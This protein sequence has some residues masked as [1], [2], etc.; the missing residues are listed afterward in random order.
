MARTY[1]QIKN[2]IT[3]AYIGDATIIAKYGLDPSKTFE[4]QFSMLSLENIIFSVVAACMLTVEVLFDI[5]KSEVT[6]IIDNMKP[7]SP[8]W[9]ADKSKQFQYGFDLLPDS[10]NFDNTGK[11]DSEI[12]D[13]KIVAYSAVIEQKQKLQIKVAKIENNDLAPL[14]LDETDAFSNYIQKIKDAGV[15][16]DLLTYPADELKLDLLIYYNPLVLNSNGERIDGTS[17]TPIPNAIR[18]YLAGIEFDSTVV[19]ADLVD[20]L[21][22]VEGV[23]IPHVNDAAY[24]YGD[25]GWIP[26]N[27]MFRPLSGYTRISDADLFITYTPRSTV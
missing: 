3:S 24:K 21:Q 6:K 16:I 5:H 12:E 27:V 13:S 7:H 14:T 23:S 19:L 20:V 26:F 8:K 10:D 15:W 11:T 18:S 22:K 17:K 2:E 25:L 9:Y 1:N 4:Q